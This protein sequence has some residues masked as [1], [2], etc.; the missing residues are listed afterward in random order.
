MASS[1]SRGRQASSDSFQDVKSV[2]KMTKEEALD[3]LRSASDCL[4]RARARI[5]KAI[6]TTK[7]RQARTDLFI[8]LGRLNMV[9]RIID[10][11]RS[12]LG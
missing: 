2:R 10:E 11:V 7:E 8:A 3:L 5:V 12:K 4:V 9:S 1:A 6:E